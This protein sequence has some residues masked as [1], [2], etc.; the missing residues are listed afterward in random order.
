MDESEL[1][2]VVLALRQLLTKPQADAPVVS[3]WQ[4]A[5]RLPDLEFDGL[6]ALSRGGH[7]VP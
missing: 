5:A 3:A 1:A 2:A 7:R 4:L 6:R